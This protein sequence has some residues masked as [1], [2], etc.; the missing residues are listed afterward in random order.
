MNKR[1]LSLAVFVII[2]ALCVPK[3]SAGSALPEQKSGI[4][5]SREEVVYANLNTS[6]GINDVYVVTTLDVAESGV[7]ID[8]GSFSTVKNLTSTAPLSREAGQVSV[9][10]LAGRFYYQGRPTEVKLPWD[11]S[12][13]YFLDGSKQDPSTLAGKSGHFEMQLSTGPSGEVT[14]FFENYVLQISITLESSKFTKLVA[15]SGTVANAGQ[16]KIVTYTVLPG[17]HGNLTL[18]AEVKDFTLYPIEIAAVPMSMQFDMPDISEITEG[19]SELSLAVGSLTLGMGQLKDGAAEVNRGA[20]ALSKGAEQLNQGFSSVNTASG[21]FLSGSAEILQ[22]LNALSTGFDL[23]M[24]SENSELSKLA[25]GMKMLAADYAK[26]DAGLRAYA[27]GV[28]ELGASFG[29]LNSGLTGLTTGTTELN[30]GLSQGYAG[31]QELNAGVQRIPGQAKEEME[32]LMS[33][34]DKSD[35]A[36]SSFLSTQNTNTT[37]VQFVMHTS[38]I[39]EF[40]VP[41]TPLPEQPSTSLWDRL[42]KLFKR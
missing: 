20:I 17:R 40:S 12:V 5:A 38:P 32:K 41:V 23:A 11:I 28:S 8:Y 2:V 31:M 29:A 9:E 24:Y 21:D 33:Q 14:S 35:F 25:Q 1:I 37:L 19:L 30:I 3:L 39:Q 34:Y 4:V 27:S 7:V 10:A 36:P 26:F 22:A 13:S 15:P 6:G 16:K 18:G 42:I